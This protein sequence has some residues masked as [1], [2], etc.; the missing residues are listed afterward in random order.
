MLSNTN[1]IS[2]ALQCSSELA[3]TFFMP[4]LVSQ[5]FCDRLMKSLRLC[6]RF[7]ICSFGKQHN[8]S[9]SLSLEIGRLNIFIA[10]IHSESAVMFTINAGFG[11]QA[12]LHSMSKDGMSKDGQKM[13]PM[14][15]TLKAGVK[16]LSTIF[17]LQTVFCYQCVE[18]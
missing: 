8:F 2:S 5:I 13:S 15:V 6:N 10:V 14:H 3:K 7:P 1:M 16:G 17:S 18:L 9:T 4:H 11:C 12:W